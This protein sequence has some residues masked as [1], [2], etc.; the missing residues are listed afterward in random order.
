[1]IQTEELPARHTSSSSEALNYGRALLNIL[2]DSASEQDRLR[3]THSAVLNVLEDFGE[4][5]QRLEG[6]EKA[7]L[8]ILEDFSEE[9]SH[10]EE[11]KS[12]VLNI[13]E[14]LGV[15]RDRLQEAQTGLLRSERA[16]RS[17]LREKETLLKE[18]HH[19]VKN[20]LQVIASLLRLQA[21]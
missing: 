6:T 8:N 7:I 13:L 4:E 18:V 14:D 16:I 1:M 11:M 12:A 2:D 15:E 17:S 3:D 10:L 20:N 19:R 21:R 5:K 9:K